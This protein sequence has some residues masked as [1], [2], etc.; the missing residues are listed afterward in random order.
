MSQLEKAKAQ[1]EQAKARVQRLQA[2]ARTEERKRDTRRKVV[3]G[4][5]LI[6]EARRDPAT[7]ETLKRWIDR[8]DPKDKAPFEGWTLSTPE[9][10]HE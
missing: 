2:K 8:L 7:A 6:A 1:L 9:A 5:I 4:G 3:L 10:D